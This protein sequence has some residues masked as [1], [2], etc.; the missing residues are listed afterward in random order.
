MIACPAG[1][2]ETAE[3]QLQFLPEM[4]A[5]SRAGGSTNLGG[6]DNTIADIGNTARLASTDPWLCYLQGLLAW[7]HSKQSEALGLFEKCMQGLLT[8]VHDMHFG[9]DFFAALDASRIMGIVRLLLSSLGGDPRSLTEAPS[10]IIGKCTRAL[11][12]LSRHT[13]ALP[14][15]QLLNAKALYLNHNL[16]AAQRKAADVLRCSPDEYAAHLLVVSIFVH[17]GKPGEAMGALEQAVSANFGIRDTPLYHVVN[18]QV[19][20][21]ANRLD[22]ARKVRLLSSFELFA[23]LLIGTGSA[24]S[25][26]GVP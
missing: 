21:A 10:P 19:L 14:E 18:A 5:A 7:K 17:Q 6:A 3:Q 25:S 24:S 15:C 1:D 9:L 12:L 26:C 8:G 2:L 11:E 20:M 4:I 13:L 23:P 22:E 16:D